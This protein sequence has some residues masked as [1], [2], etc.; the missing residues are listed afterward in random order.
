VIYRSIKGKNRWLFTF[1]PPGGNVA[2]AGGVVDGAG[3]VGVA[4]AV[5]VDVASAGAVAVKVAVAVGGNGVEVAVAVGVEPGATVKVGLGVCVAVGV[6]VGVTPGIDVAVDV[7][8]A[9]G[10]DAMV[11]VG[12]G[13]DVA[14]G[15]AVETFGLF[16]ALL[17]PEALPW[18]STIRAVRFVARAG[19][20]RG[21]EKLPSVAAVVRPRKN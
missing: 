4:V 6:I 19:P 14:V 16:C 17:K 1:V 2:S 20:D 7:N 10:V 18:A 13:V 3:L 11:D 21:K 5:A 15:V 8:V 12:V 9:V